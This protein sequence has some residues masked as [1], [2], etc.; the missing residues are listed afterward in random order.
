ML[1][2]MPLRDSVYGRVKDLEASYLGADAV[3]R[4]AR[5]EL[6]WEREPF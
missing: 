5:E 3:A 2:S 6:A 4:M 1:A